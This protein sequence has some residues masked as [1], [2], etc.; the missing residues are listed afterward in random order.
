MQ[1]NRPAL[2]SIW[3]IGIGFNGTSHMSSGPGVIAFGRSCQ[4]FQRDFLKD[5]EV[6]HPHPGLR[7]DPTNYL[8]C[9]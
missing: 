5:D 7:I 3:D 4:E 9:K 8:S 6:V 2:S 1:V